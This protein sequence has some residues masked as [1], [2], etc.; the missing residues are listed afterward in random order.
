MEGEIAKLL[1][2]YP[3]YIV[4]KKTKK[5]SPEIQIKSK[6]IEYKKATTKELLIRQLDNTKFGKNIDR[7]N[8][9]GVDEEKS[10]DKRKVGK[11]CESITLGLFRLRG[12][13]KD[14]PKV[15]TKLTE[16]K[17]EL[18]ELA[19]KYIKEECPDF[20]YTTICINKNLV[21]KKHRDKYNASKSIIV[22]LG[23]YEGGNLYIEGVKHNI[24][25]KP[26]LF[27]GTKEHWNDEITSGTKYSLIFFTL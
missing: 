13:K 1:A 4:P 25:N 2:E 23:D 3:E 20:E 26:L 17:V 9:S 16:K 18:Y 27:D 5:T 10:T 7:P 14:A 6:T 11:P 8:V 15:L 12:T 21:C 19:Q 24:K 22:G